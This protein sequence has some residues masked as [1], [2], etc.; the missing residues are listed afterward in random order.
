AGGRAFV[1]VVEQVVLA[2]VADVP[3]K[4]AFDLG[5]GSGTIQERARQAREH[6]DGENPSNHETPP[7]LPRL[8]RRML[9]LVRQEIGESRG[10]LG[11]LNRAGGL[12]RPGSSCG[13]GDHCGGRSAWRGSTP[14]GL[15]ALVLER[16][17]ARAG[18]SDENLFAALAE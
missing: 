12:V 11:E 15:R 9:A 3:L 4:T 16:V 13:G 1:V 14:P 8:L 5:R 2:L 18:P 10:W 7:A 6:A 17:S